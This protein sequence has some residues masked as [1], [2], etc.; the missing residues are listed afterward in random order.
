[1]EWAE[2]IE[3]QNTQI[4][5]VGGIIASIALIVGGLGITNIMLA[6][7]TERIREIGLRMAVGAGPRDI[8]RQFLTEAMLIS[9][10]GGIIGTLI[11]GGAQASIQSLV[12]NAADSR[13]QGRTMGSVTALSSMM[14]FEGD[15]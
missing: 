14:A 9:F 11:G 12:S 10:G 13:S 15:R 8:Q 3:K 2:G 6:S 7:I 4:K 5:L 1:M